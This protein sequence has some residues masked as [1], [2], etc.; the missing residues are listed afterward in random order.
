MKQIKPSNKTPMPCIIGPTASG[1]TS[2]AVHLATRFSGEIISADSRQVYRGMDIGT[3][4]DLEE[5]GD[6]PYHL[7]DIVDPGHEYNLFEF[8]QN[9]CDV[10]ESI[11]AHQNLPILVGGTALYM[12]A[13]LSRYQLTP[14]NNDATL[15]ARLDTLSDDALAERLLTLKPEQHNTTDLKDRDRLIRAIEIA[16]AERQT[17][18]SIAWPDFHPLII[19][20]QSERSE[21]RKR[22][23][24]RLKRRL[25]EGMI[26]EVKNLHEQGL[27]WE[28]LDFYGLE[29][30]YIARHLQ[31]ELNYNDMF[32]KLNSA[33]HQFAKQQ[34]KWFRKFAEKGH[35]I[36]WIP[37]GASLN[38]EAEEWLQS[39][40][41][42]CTT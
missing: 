23:T 7:I 14:A 4:K 28:Q 25:Q 31:G 2:L 35:T 8:A 20:I 17:T 16:E 1:K 18:T 37:T 39:Q 15:R 13:V 3:G 41:Q 22:I 10:F 42:Q 32:Q 27:S 26:E 6:I 19:G 40:L 5:Y 9:F 11:R 12:D 34:D 33:I 29:Y 21:T 36:H 38:T 24:E 30:R